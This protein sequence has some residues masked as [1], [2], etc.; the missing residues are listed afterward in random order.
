[1]RSFPGGRRSSGRSQL[2]ACPSTKMG[3]RIGDPMRIAQIS[4]LTEAVPP[5][6]YGGTERVISWLT[7]E[8]VGLGHDVTLFASAI[9]APRRGLRR[10]GRARCAST[11]RSAIPIACISRC[12]SRCAGGL[13]I[14]TSCISIWTTSHFPCSRDNPHRSL[15]HYMD[16]SIYPSISRHSRRSRQCR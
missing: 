1:M 10:S 11:V 7:E 14:L 13:R 4:P 3:R 5:K 8:L 15:R 2:F 16:A 9:P 12:L 6:L